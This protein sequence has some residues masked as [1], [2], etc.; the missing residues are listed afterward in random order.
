MS[1]TFL[2]KP[3][4][5]PLQKKIFDYITRDK[6]IAS[7]FYFTGGT[8]LAAFYLM[9]RESEDLD[10][11]SE[12]E[13]EAAEIEELMKNLAT[14]LN[15]NYRYTE[16][17]RTKIFEFVEKNKLLMKVDFAYYPYKR[18]NESNKYHE[19]EVDSLRDIATNKLLTINQRTDVKD[20]VDLYFLL[21][22]FTLW[23]L[24]YG[25]EA[26]F[27]MEMDLIL[28]SSD[29]L[30]ATQFDFLPKMLVPLKLAELKKFFKQQARDLAKTVVE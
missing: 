1:I 12:E 8:A 2:S 25:V 20:F 14:T 28:L 21:K 23:D 22:E 30:K 15:L 9:H 16:L 26:K 6:S 29:F 17:E 7:R 27:R 18:L 3:K 13:F 5:I 11:F 10:F 4:F 24:M 19:V